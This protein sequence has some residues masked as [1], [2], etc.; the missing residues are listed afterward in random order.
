M[1]LSVIT[2]MELVAFIL[3]V[4][5]TYLMS[6]MHKTAGEEA[7]KKIIL[8]AE[9]TEQDYLPFVLFCFVFY[10]GVHGHHLSMEY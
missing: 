3:F 8:N 1:F 4:I 9:Q 10:S 2:V 6:S 5:Y 7:E